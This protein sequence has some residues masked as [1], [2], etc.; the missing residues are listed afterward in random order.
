M[1]R[2]FD[3]EVKNDD[4]LEKMIKKEKLNPQMISLCGTIFLWDVFI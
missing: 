4:F 3:L 2:I 1:V